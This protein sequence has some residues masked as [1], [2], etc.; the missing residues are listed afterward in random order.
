MNPTTYACCITCSNGKRFAEEEFELFRN[1]SMEVGAELFRNEHLYGALL[2]QV[3]KDLDKQ[4]KLLNL[5]SIIPELQLATFHQCCRS[6]TYNYNQNFYPDEYRLKDTCDRVNTC[7]NK[8]N[9]TKF[10]LDKGEGA[11]NLAKLK[12]DNLMKMIRAHLKMQNDVFEDGFDQVLLRAVNDESGNLGKA[13]NLRSLKAVYDTQAD[14][15]KKNLRSLTDKKQFHSN[16]SSYELALRQV[17]FE[18][19]KYHHC[20]KMCRDAKQLDYS[21][22][23][24][25]V[26]SRRA[27]TQCF[28][29]YSEQFCAKPIE[30]S[31]GFMPNHNNT[32]CIKL[33]ECAEKLDDCLPES[34]YCV[35]HFNGYTCECRDG[36]RY[37]LLSKKCVNVDECLENARICPEHSYCKDLVGTY[38]CVCFEGLFMNDFRQCMPFLTRQLGSAPAES[39]G[40]LYLPPNQAED[41]DLEEKQMLAEKMM[42]EKTTMDGLKK[43][44]LVP[45]DPIKDGTDKITDTIANKNLTNRQ[46]NAE[47]KQSTGGQVTS[48]ESPARSDE[49]SLPTNNQPVENRQTNSE[50]TV[51]PIERGEMQPK[52]EP[53]SEPLTEPANEQ[54]ISPKLREEPTPSPISESLAQS[55]KQ[56]YLNEM[57][58]NNKLKQPEVRPILEAVGDNP[59]PKGYFLSLASSRM[60][61]C[62]DINECTDSALNNCTANETCIN[63]PGTYGCQP[64]NEC[65]PNYKA[66]NVTVHTVDQHH[67][68]TSSTRAS[69]YVFLLILAC[70]VIFISIVFVFTYFVY[71]R[72]SFNYS[73]DP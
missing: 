66:L 51:Q 4:C 13:E 12:T 45:G 37:N 52:N 46:S 54:T 73:Y 72:F 44:L 39:N 69:T 16:I 60:R 10:N 43:G 25:T 22:T 3:D 41:E 40:T 59:C 34:E 23:Y 1:K 62:V 42:F 11:K 61:T 65:P 70:F 17:P 64:K 28:H 33:D 9:H 56:K 67:Y 15:H 58:N 5:V 36:Y 57:L 47:E 6:W 35:K 71:R 48:V 38:E 49:D 8:Q 20:N 2:N 31:A 32:I 7:L 18:K 30:C 63:L 50:S 19:F 26:S 24:T 21:E 29:N 27:F 68:E 55:D 53:V 14:F